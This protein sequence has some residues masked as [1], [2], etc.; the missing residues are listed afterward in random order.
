MDVCKGNIFWTAEPFVA[1][2]DIILHYQSQS[3]MW[4]D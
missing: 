2:L 3:V 4:K 1:K